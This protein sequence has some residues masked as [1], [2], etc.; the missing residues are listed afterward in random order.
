MW[1]LDGGLDSVGY[2]FRCQHLQVSLCLSNENDLL[3]ADRL[4]E[5]V[6][7]REEGD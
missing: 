7:G 1:D 5:R 3:T 4:V 6:G 2:D